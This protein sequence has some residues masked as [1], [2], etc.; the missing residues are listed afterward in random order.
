MTG[1][2]GRTDEQFLNS[3]G[4][5]LTQTVLEGSRNSDYSQQAA[6]RKMKSDSIVLNSKQF[7]AVKITQSFHSADCTNIYSVATFDRISQRACLGTLQQS[8]L[9]VSREA[10]L[11][12]KGDRSRSKSATFSLS[13][14]VASV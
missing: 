5:T 13:A 9:K 1:Q 3:G 14:G 10:L 8:Y 6:L 11:E 12:M 2:A 4:R 7:S